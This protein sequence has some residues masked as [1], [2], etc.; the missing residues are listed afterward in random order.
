MK[1]KLNK[2]LSN[3]K[4]LMDK[5]T[6]MQEK[7]ILKLYEQLKDMN[8]TTEQRE[9]RILKLEGQLKKSDDEYETLNNRYGNI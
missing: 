2:S 6:E 5:R 3:D 1:T 7:K 4:N 9:H 8:S